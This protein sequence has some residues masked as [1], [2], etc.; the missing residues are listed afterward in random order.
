MNGMKILHLL[1]IVV[2]LST[3]FAH[4][5]GQHDLSELLDNA[6]KGDI[7]A[8]C[9]LGAAYFNGEKTLKD[10]F[11]AK[12]WIKKAYDKGSTRAKKLWNDLELWRYSGKCEASFDDEL[13]PKY[14]KGDIFNDPVTGTKFIFVP[15]GC[16]LMGCHNAAT[17][18][19]KNETP[20]RRVCLDGFWIGQFEVTQNLWYRVMGSNPSRFSSNLSRPVE[21]VSFDDIQKFINLL[22]AQ[23]KQK[24]SLPTEAQ[25]EYACRNGGKT[26][27]FPWGSES[28][29]PHANCG[30]CDSG[31][32]YGETAPVGTFPPNDLGLYDM[33]GNVKEWCQDI[34]NKGRSRVVRGGAFIDNTSNL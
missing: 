20:M 6:R 2:L 28:H 12:C 8:M 26:I 7:E 29:R 15:K 27:N 32:F 21:N 34:Y 22:K 25:W 17:N 19:K 31:S 14:N 11:K 9:D 33:G 16:F 4:A 10:P 13:S 23:S 30:T 3:P 24:F 5:D 18:C 1:I